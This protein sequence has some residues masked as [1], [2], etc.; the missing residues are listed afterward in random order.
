MQI[1]YCCTQF[2]TVAATTATLWCFQEMKVS[3]QKP[4]T[5]SGCLRHLRKIEKIVSEVFKHDDRKNSKKRMT[6]KYVDDDNH[7]RHE[8]LKETTS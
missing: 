2:A 1:S 6:K 5:T 4:P 3:F 7:L 8:Q